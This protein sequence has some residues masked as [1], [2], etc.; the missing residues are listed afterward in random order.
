M[1][2]SSKLADDVCGVGKKGGGR[3]REC[4]ERTGGMGNGEG[5][6]KSVKLSLHC[7]ERRG[8]MGEGRGNCRSVLPP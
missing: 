4:G 6:R 7:P 3:A 1:I 8:R 2:N 5:E